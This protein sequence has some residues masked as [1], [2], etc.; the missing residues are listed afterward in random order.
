MEYVIITPV[1]NEAA[2]V[3]RTLRSVVNQTV[4]PTQWIL[5]DDNSNDATP[6]I[7]KKY[8]KQYPFITRVSYPEPTKRIPGQGVIRAFNYGVQFVTQENYD[9]IVKLDADLELPSDYFEILFRA[10][11][12]DPELGIVS[13]VSDETDGRIV[14]RSIREHTYGFSKVYRRSCFEA[15]RPM[16]EFK[17]WD[18]VDNL[19]ANVKGFKTRIIP[20]AQVL[21]LKKMES[22]S[23]MFCENYLKGFYSG[24]MRYLPLFA[25]VKG[26]KTVLERPYVIGGLIY[27]IGYLNNRL[28]GRSRYPDLQVIEHL[29]KQQAARLRAMFTFSKQADQYRFL[30]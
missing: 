3:E 12:E 14:K 24:H 4:S 17:T 16:D 21:H 28:I 19:K 20:E 15:I 18:L 27:I 29:R 1:R 30:K 6:E 5:V 9:F 25:L 26:C 10:F 11:E 13:G 2:V 23:G 7:I 8:S 22:A